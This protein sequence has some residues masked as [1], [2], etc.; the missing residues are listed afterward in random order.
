MASAPTRPVLRYHGGK[1]M[2]APWIISHFPRHQ[3]YCEP[4]CGAASVL[5]RK[6]RAHAETINDLD[7]DVVNLFRVLRDPEQSQ[8][9]AA[10][11]NLT[12]WAREEFVAS[13]APSADPVE[14][15]RRTVA[16]CYM[17]FGTSSRRRGMTGF[18]AR[19]YRESQT[20]VTDWTNYP[21]SVARVAQRLR[22]VCIDSRPLREYVR[23]RFVCAIC[24]NRMTT[25]EY[26][27]NDERIIL[28]EEVSFFTVLRTLT[29]EQRL[30]LRG[31]INSFESRSR[32]CASCLETLQHLDPADTS[33]FC[34][35]CNAPG[36]DEQDN[37]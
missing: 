35:A 9:L 32:Q 18:R 5:M 22:G 6:P 31:L 33:E 13:Y 11:L 12:P 1:W 34:D 30:A 10:L 21:E 15:A 16:R 8:S 25:V 28:P 23:R 37:S 26:G 27:E 7:G 17:G 2:L 4:F 20:G 36:G 19:P 14:H 29:S 3:I 24:K